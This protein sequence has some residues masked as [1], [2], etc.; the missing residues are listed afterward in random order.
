MSRWVAT[1][2]TR[3]PERG[4]KPSYRNSDLNF[5]SSFR[6]AGTPTPNR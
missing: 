4:P 1:V 2:A 3:A 6:W 5:P